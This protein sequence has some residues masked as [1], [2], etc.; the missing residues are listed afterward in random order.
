[1]ELLKRALTDTLP[2]DE[3]RD[4]FFNGV[5]TAE[6]INLIL[7]EGIKDSYVKDGYVNPNRAETMVGMPRLSNFQFCIEQAIENNIDGDVIETDV[8][9]GGSCILAAAVIENRKSDKKVYVADSFEGLPKPEAKYIADKGDKHHTHEHLKISLDQVKANFKKYG[10]LNK[11][12]CFIKGFFKDS[13]KSVPFKKLSVL[14][15]DGD[16]YSSTIEVLESLYDKLSIG[17]YLIVDDYALPA[18]KQAIDDYRSDNN[19]DDELIRIDWTGVYWVK[20]K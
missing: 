7:S 4:K 20:T 19:I 1:M 11:N 13:L 10:Y 8:W 17:G 14:R 6:E 2:N 18:C 12:V 5:L 16:M 15:L 9:R 3:L